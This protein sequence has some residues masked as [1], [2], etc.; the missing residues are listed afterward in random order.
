MS[1]PFIH[2]RSLS[3]YSLSE[4]S[5]KI[6]SLVE[7]AKKNEMPAIAITDTSNL[8]G[9]LEF[10]LKMISNGIQPIIGIQVNISQDGKEDNDIGEV[11]LLAKNEIGYSS[12]IELKEGLQKLINW[13][14]DQLKQS[15]VVK[16]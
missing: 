9:A 1:K 2:L 16:N 8:F 14:A 3:S 5:L 12:T 6:K 11:V 15:K 10:S 13:R 4:S 7:L